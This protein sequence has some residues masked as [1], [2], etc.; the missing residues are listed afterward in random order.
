[1]P[2]DS[3]TFP[4]TTPTISAGIERISVLKEKRL[5]SN[6]PELVVHVLVYE[7]GG[8]ENIIPQVML[9]YLV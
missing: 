9:V 1:M 3:P 7:F 2:L 6:D 8:K 5:L 4:L